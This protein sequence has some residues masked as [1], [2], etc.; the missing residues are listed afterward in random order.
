MKNTLRAVN[1]F[2]ALALI[3][4]GCD[5]VSPDA[6][7]QF[8]QTLQANMTPVV[9]T[10]EVVVK[11]VEQVVLTATLAPTP[12][13]TPVPAFM[14]APVQPEPGLQRAVTISLAALGEH[15]QLL[16]FTRAPN[17]EL[18]AWVRDNAYPDT[19]LCGA[20]LYFPGLGS[21]LVLTTSNF[22]KTINE[23]R[24]FTAQNGCV[25]VSLERGKAQVQKILEHYQG[26]YS[27]LRANK[28]FTSANEVIQYIQQYLAKSKDK[29]PYELNIV[30]IPMVAEDLGNTSLAL[31][32][33]KNM[34]KGIG[35]QGPY[36]F[37]FTGEDIS[38]D[39]SET[40]H[41]P[42]VYARQFNPSDVV[43]NLPLLG[44]RA[45]QLKVSA[46]DNSL[47]KTNPLTQQ[48]ILTLNFDQNY[49]EQLVYSGA[50]TAGLG[51]IYEWVDSKTVYT[52]PVFIPLLPMTGINHLYDGVLAQ[53]WVPLRDY[54]SGKTQQLHS[55]MVDAYIQPARARIKNTYFDFLI[56][57]EKQSQ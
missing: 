36:Q 52:N 26:I 7:G 51:S 30:L 10:Q 57:E 33:P 54:F 8:Q 28:N 9:V 17:G 34:F 12:T 5:M 38:Y 41:V 21:L 37:D 31:E 20:P 6:I 42:L 22:Y 50:F 44:E 25:A 19:L 3:L 29:H 2:L 39:G 14:G 1:I 35:C 56:F 16:L 13:T 24:I 47:F 53:A 32:C 55:S 4:A 43:D 40:R 15:M 18:V 48:E 49:W 23:Q 46:A 11:T 45:K 27:A